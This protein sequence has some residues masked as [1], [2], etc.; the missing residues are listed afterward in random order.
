MIVPF[1]TLPPNSRIWIYQCERALSTIEQQHISDKLA[2]FLESWKRHG[3]DLKAAFTIKYNRFIVLAVDE[4]FR[5]VSG[6]SIDASVQFMQALEKELAA[7]LLDKMQV[8][9]KNETA[10]Q[11]ATMADFKDLAKTGKVDANTIV[12]NNMVQTIAAF[13][14]DWEVPVNKS[15]HQ[16]LLV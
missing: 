3:D 13:N 7:T 5:D 6:C 11:I 14:S 2:P 15:W 16:R 12:F 8:A 9:Y 4:N 1:N 10:I